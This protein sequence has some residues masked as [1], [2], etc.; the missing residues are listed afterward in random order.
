[1]QS[2]KGLVAKS[3]PKE[4]KEP[5]GSR[6]PSQSQPIVCFNCDKPGHIAKNCRNPKKGPKAMGRAG[7]FTNVFVQ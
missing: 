3:V 2:Q 7:R 4:S 1:M 6:V 5:S